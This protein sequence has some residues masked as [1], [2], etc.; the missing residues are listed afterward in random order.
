MPKKL[1]F[2][3][4]KDY[5]LLSS[6]ALLPIADNLSAP[7]RFTPLIVRFPAP[8]KP[9]FSHFREISIWREIWKIVRFFLTLRRNQGKSG[10]RVSANHPQV[11]SPSPPYF[12]LNAAPGLRAM[13][14]LHDR[15]RPM[16]PLRDNKCLPESM[17]EQTVSLFKCF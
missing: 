8:P 9:D 7:Q 5:N 14:R 10:L 3:K 4:I 15:H 12:L 17:W 13:F 6:P 11:A 2:R 16:A 1:R